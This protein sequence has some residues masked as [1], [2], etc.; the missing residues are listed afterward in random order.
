[1]SNQEFDK[2]YTHWQ[3]F[4]MHVGERIKAL[5]ELRGL[6]QG[7]LSKLSGVSKPY[8][9]QFEKN[10]FN[11]GHQTLE[12]LARAL[13]IPLP[14]LVD[15]ELWAQRRPGFIVAKAALSAFL[16]KQSIS[17]RYRSLLIDALEKDVCSF[18]EPEGWENAYRLVKLQETRGPAIAE[19]PTRAVQV[20][21]NSLLQPKH[22]TNSRGKGR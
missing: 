9:S 17:A 15:N 11:I 4:Y 14:D 2:S 6:S 7:R 10:E 19:I 8:I 5:R 13:R 18:S 20:E 21:R 1:M 16:V 12:S 3:Y 22:L